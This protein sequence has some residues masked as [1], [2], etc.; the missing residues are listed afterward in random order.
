[1][2]EKKSFLL[3]TSYL[4]NVEILSDE[5]AGQLLKAIYAFVNDNEIPKLDR[6]VQL[7]F[8]P[9]KAHLERDK[10]K[11]KEICRKR[12]ENIQKRWEKTKNTNEYNCIQTDTNYTDNENENENVNV[13]EN[14]NDNDYENAYDNEND[15]PFP[16]LS[17]TLTEYNALCDK[18]GKARTDMYAQKIQCYEKSSPEV[19]TDVY[20]FMTAW[21]ENEM[22]D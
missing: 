13:N 17:L 7:T 3:Y 1:M 20:G 6:V 21:M 5:E 9:I 22:L 8:N 10:E 16:Y 12:S 19:Y 14:V 4:D 2:A 18:F 11:Y 15:K